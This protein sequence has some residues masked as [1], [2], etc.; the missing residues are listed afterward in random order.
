MSV[1]VLICLIFCAGEPTGSNEKV[2]QIALGNDFTLSCSCNTG[3]ACW[4]GPKSSNTMRVNFEGIEYL[5]IKDFQN[6]N[7]GSSNDHSI[8]FRAS[9]GDSLF[10]FCKDLISSSVKAT[11]SWRPHSL[12]QYITLQPDSAVKRFHFSAK[13]NDFSLTISNIDWGD[14][15]TYECQRVKDLS[16]AKTSFELVVVRVHADP[17]QTLSI[18][19]GED[20][21]LQCEVSYRFPHIQLRWINMDTKENFP[22]PHQLRNV[23]MGQRN[24][25]CAVFIGST[26]KALIPL[27]LNIS[28][29]FTTTAR[30][31][32][33]TTHYHTSDESKTLL[34]TTRNNRWT[35][36][37]ADSEG[38]SHPQ[39]NLILITSGFSFILVVTL[40]A[41]YWRRRTKNNAEAEH[42]ALCMR[43]SIT[44]A[45]VSFRQKSERRKT[46]EED[47]PMWERDSVTYAEVSF[48]QKPDDV[49]SECEPVSVSKDKVQHKP[50]SFCFISVSLYKRPHLFCL[51]LFRR[52]IQPNKK[53][54]IHLLTYLNV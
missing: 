26:L 4:E 29:Y 21:K 14:S 10:L 36:S 23:T 42:P 30:S 6:Q 18:T 17:Q 5:L 2:T 12:G 7:R 27:T 8:L 54:C 3:Q 43:D 13:D 31:S 46:L 33:P 48:R 47:L 49:S 40:G 37:E 41:V 35:T 25:M 15:G 51:L 16:A 11:W 45:E 44:Y 32:T 34:Q 39:K 53:S 38:T 24:W 28:Q 19:E 50:I 1:R 22:N 9:E 52:T 20:V